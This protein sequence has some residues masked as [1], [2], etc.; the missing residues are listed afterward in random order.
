MDQRREKNS[1]ENTGNNPLV[2]CKNGI[3][4]VK[5]I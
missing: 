4:G 5:Y 1:T 2:H 3:L